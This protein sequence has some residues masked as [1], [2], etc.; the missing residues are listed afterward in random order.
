MH[1]HSD[2]EPFHRQ[3]GH[4]ESLWDAFAYIKYHDKSYYIHHI[5]KKK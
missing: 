2:R 1:R 4:Y 3:H 5:P